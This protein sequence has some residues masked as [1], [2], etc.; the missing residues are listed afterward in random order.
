MAKD[1][2]VPPG[3]GDVKAHMYA[4]GGSEHEWQPFKYTRL[5]TNAFVIE[6]NKV[7]PALVLLNDCSNWSLIVQSPIVRS[8]LLLGFKKRGFGAGL[9]V[10]LISTI[11]EPRGEPVGEGDQMDD[12]T[13]LPC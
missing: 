1:S 9:C 7:R 8:Q 5:Y 4:Q 11:L 13:C 3:L 10:F 2:D 6:G 12:S